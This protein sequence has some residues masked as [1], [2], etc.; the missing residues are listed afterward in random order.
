MPD[1]FHERKQQKPLQSKE[2]VGSLDQSMTAE[3]DAE[4]EVLLAEFTGGK[5]SLGNS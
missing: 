1:W 4:F 5:R 2:R 3:E